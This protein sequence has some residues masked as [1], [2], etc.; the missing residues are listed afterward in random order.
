MAVPNRPPSQ[1]KYPVQYM[2]NASLDEDFGV[3][4]R[5]TLGY[6]GVSLQRSTADSMALKIT[7]VGSVTYLATAAPGTAEATAKWRVK[8]IDE[9][10]GMV[11][12][13]SDGDA[14]FDNV[15]TDLTA[16]SYS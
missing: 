2:E 4:T 16:L 5:E 14:D 1:S 8:K 9:T 13:W 10:S 3:L 6:D 7:V 12:T 15:A 11:I